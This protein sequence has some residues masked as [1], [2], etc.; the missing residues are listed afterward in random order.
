MGA[1]ERPGRQ[2]GLG[3][4]FK[5]FVL[6]GCDLIQAGSGLDRASTDV[7]IVHAVLDFRDEAMCQ[8]FNRLV[9]DM[10][11]AEFIFQ[12]AGDGDDVQPARLA[13]LL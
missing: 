13:M 8:L 7:G 4:G 9:L 3:S 6:G 10:R 2:L 11:A 5:D 12:V 1:D